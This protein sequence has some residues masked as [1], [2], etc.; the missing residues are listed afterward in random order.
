VSKQISSLRATGI[1]LD[2]EVEIP[3][4]FL[5]FTDLKACSQLCAEVAKYQTFFFILRAAGLPAAFNSTRC[6]PHGELVGGFEQENS[7]LALYLYQKKKK[8]KQKD[9]LHPINIIHHTRGLCSDQQGVHQRGR[10]PSRLP[11]RKAC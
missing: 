7:I 10:C 2:L 6:T 8:K 9:A 1:F 4:L 5:A 11:R 3:N